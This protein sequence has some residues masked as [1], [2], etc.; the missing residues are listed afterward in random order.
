M[1]TYK[2][3]PDTRNTTTG[4]NQEIR[5]HQPVYEQEQIYIKADKKLEAKS[6]NLRQ[7]L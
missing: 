5:F 6:A 1:T 4:D 2:V 7:F 3:I